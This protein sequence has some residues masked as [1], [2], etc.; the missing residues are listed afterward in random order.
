MHDTFACSI[1][2]IS[3]FSGFNSRVCVEIL[4]RLSNIYSSFQ[5][6]CL[7]HI[8]ILQKLKD[9]MTNNTTAFHT[10]PNNFL[11]ASVV[12]KFIAMIIGV[13]GNVTVITHTILSSKEKTATSYLVG[14]LAL[15]DLLVCSTFYP[16]WIIEFIQII[17]NIDN[18]QDL[19]C[20]FSRSTV[21]AFMFA[22]IATLLAITVDRYVYIVKPLRYPQIVTHRR[23]FLAVA[24]IWITVC[25]LLIV[26][27]IHY[28]SFGVEFHSFCYIPDSIFNFRIGVN[29]CFTFLIIFLNV[30]IL[31]LARKQR[32]R[33]FA[34]ATISSV[35]NPTAESANRMRVVLRFFVALKTS[36]TFAIVVAVLTICVLTPTVVGWI[37]RTFYSARSRQI[38]YVVFN[39]EFY[40]INSVVNAFIYGMRHVKYRKAYLHILFKLFFCHKSTS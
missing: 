34:D 10:I 3:V 21:W 26:F 6:C 11:L 4:T 40:G 33:I 38:W 12:F 29:G 32:N 27:Y 30:R 14:N 5:F 31:F 39:Y 19:F 35:D 8:L 23:V 1:I 37:L 7:V 16:I 15:A 36:K 28:K 2:R 9:I 18:D 24:G 22:S 13:L 25:C 17:M 20:K